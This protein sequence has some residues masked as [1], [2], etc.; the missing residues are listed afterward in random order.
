MA[1]PTH[2]FQHKYTH[3]LTVGDALGAVLA[4]LRAVVEGHVLLRHQEVVLKHVLLSL[5]DRLL[6]RL[7]VYEFVGMCECESSRVERGVVGWV[8]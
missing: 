5:A 8:T 3:A 1:R 2:S 7:L 6:D 4:L